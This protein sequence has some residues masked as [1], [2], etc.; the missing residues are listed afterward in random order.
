MV[1]EL[2]EIFDDRMGTLNGRHRMR[3]VYLNP[4]HVVSIYDSPETKQILSE[5]GLP[6]GI[7]EHV[8]FSTVTV[9]KG[10]YG[11]EVVVVGAPSEVRDKLF[12]QKTLLKG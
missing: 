10:T 9:N 7:S 12:L 5:G 8:S 6:E 11:Q 2:I 3:T 1:I 4:E